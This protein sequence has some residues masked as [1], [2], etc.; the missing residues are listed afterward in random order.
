M[1]PSV[2]AALRVLSRAPLPSS[3]PPTSSPSLTPP[4]VAPSPPSTSAPHDGIVVVGFVGSSS[5]TDLSQLIN[6][7]VN[8]NTFGSGRLDKDLIGSNGSD[9]F[10]HRKVS[11]H[12]DAEKG[13]VFLQFSSSLSSLESLSMS[14]SSSSSSSSYWVDGSVPEL[15]ESE[16]EDLKG[17]L[18][19]FSVC[20][21]IIF[22]H[23]GL[24]FDTQVL[25]KF[26]LLQTS[27][28][29]LS[30]FIKFDDTPKSNSNADPSSA[31][32]HTNTS[33]P[34]LVQRGHHVPVTS[35]SL[36][37]SMGQSSPVIL[38]V[39]QDSISDPST[40]VSTTDNATFGKA[41]SSFR[42]R[43][44]ASLDAQLRFLMKKLHLSLRVTGKSSYL[45]LFSLDASRV[46]TLIDRSTNRKGEPLNYL[47][48]LIDTLLTSKLSVDFLTNE[49][50]SHFTNN[51]EVQIIRDFI[52]R[53]SEMLRGRGG[54]AAG[55]SG[56]NSVSGVGMAAAAIA[57][58]TSATVKP[59]MGL[60]L[61]GL[62]K[63]LSASTLILNSL[64]CSEKIFTE[65]KSENNI[66]IEAALSC[67]E[68][69]A[70]VNTKFSVSWCESALPVAREVYLR[71]L[72]PFYRTCTHKEHLTKALEAFRAAVKGPAV[73]AFMI[74]LEKDCNSIWENGRQQC[75]VSSLTGKPCMLQRHNMDDSVVK[76]QHC[77]GYF[78][79]HA[80][81]CGR[82]RTLRDDP[83][84]IETANVK[85]CVLPRCEGLLPTV[86][87]P[88][89]VGVSPIMNSAWRL[90]RVGGAGYYKPEKGLLQTGFCIREKY[91]FQW[92]I[93]NALDTVANDQSS[94]VESFE[95]ISEGREMH[96]LNVSSKKQ[97]TADLG[98]HFGKGLPSSTTKKP[99]AEVVAGTIMTDTDF[100]AL[101]KMHPKPSVNH[102]DTKQNKSSGPQNETKN[103]SKNFSQDIKVGDNVVTVINKDEGTK[104]NKSM[105]EF[106]VF[107][108]FEHEC[109]HG[110]RFLL[111]EK[112][113][114]GLDS[115][116]LCEKDQQRNV[117]NKKGFPAKVLQASTTNA[118]KL[119]EVSVK[120]TGQ[121]VGMSGVAD[122]NEKYRDGGRAYSLLNRN[123][124]IFMNCPHCG[125]SEKHDSRKIRFSGTISQLQ[126]IIIVTPPF[127]VLLATCPVVQF[128]D[129]CLPDSVSNREQQSKFGFGSRI[130]LPPDSFLTLK[131][132]F[133][134]GV[135][136][137]KG[138]LYPLNPLEH[139][140]ERTA[141]LVEGTA[142]QLVSIGNFHTVV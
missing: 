131:L 103:K 53:Q 80:C 15:E 137:D 62:D 8:S 63:W 14:S 98:I 86:E 2:G 101:Q 73:N 52:F 19:M 49:K 18:F 33:F 89:A 120:H 87:I 44:I 67:L 24:R 31:T 70:N 65:G 138:G 54:G 16:L 26:R 47:T 90:M 127:P 141:W 20:H 21:V 130:M 114:K 34:Q 51:E 9:W 126:R 132:P 56:S 74:K 140:P 117:V 76:R 100:P 88:P 109:P 92:K 105:R 107:V 133:I 123:L 118:N 5:S 17:M 77:S 11:Y 124:P 135:E 64:T 35:S 69:G 10:R 3:T 6:R 37:A 60:E 139:Q 110:H 99:F 40:S 38:F 119:K 13:I 41:D 112:H 85:F 81:A 111:S 113:L 128:E 58:V 36:S 142:L 12:F 116:F 45:P 61:P 93:R 25:K 78:F 106:I 23:D 125:R 1:D 91:L 134:Y 68:R 28:Q 108:G 50:T 27:K 48:G 82:S 46:I 71:D 79:L 136:T 43:L 84:D 66:N 115:P 55:N 75:D 39:L 95:M 7:I 97:V 104:E 30:Q 83:F 32:T 122:E 29:A 96:Q 59:V 42:K 22:V 102:K 94:T 121:P 57:A 72:P 4:S 129:S